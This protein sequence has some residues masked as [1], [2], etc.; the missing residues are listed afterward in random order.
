MA[1]ERFKGRSNQEI[2]G[3]ALDG[4][5]AFISIQAFIP[6][7]TINEDKSLTEQEDSDSDDDS[8]EPPPMVPYYPEVDSSDDEDSNNDDESADPPPEFAKTYRTK[9]GQDLKAKQQL[10]IKK[11][12]KE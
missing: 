8:V 5:T 10:W 9:I 12:L 3:I 6:V 2:A 11:K 1:P 4:E 7:E